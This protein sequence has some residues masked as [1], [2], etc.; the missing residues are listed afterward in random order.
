M[1]P[2]LAVIRCLLFNV[3]AE[4]QEAVTHFECRKV[5][6][7]PWPMLCMY[8]YLGLTVSLQH[9]A[10]LLVSVESITST[11]AGS[12][13]ASHQSQHPSARGFSS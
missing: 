5:T 12:L 2:I 7:W 6:D 11:V 3:F 4:E 10:L 1:F 9:T 13:R 8:W